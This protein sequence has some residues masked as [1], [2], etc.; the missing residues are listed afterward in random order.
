MHATLKRLFRIAYLLLSFSAFM[1]S[2]SESEPINEP[3]LPEIQVDDMDEEEDIEDETEDQEQANNGD[4]DN[5]TETEEV[6]ETSDE[7]ESEE[8]GN[9]TEDETSTNSNF[10]VIQLSGDETSAV[11]DSLV[12]A[13][14]AVGRADLTGTVKSVILTDENTEITEEG[15]SPKKLD[16]GFVLIGGDDLNSEGNTD[17]EKDISM[18][19]FI[20]GIEYRFG[21]SVPSGGKFMDC[22][23]D[24][25][26]DFEKKEMIFDNTTVS[27]T[28]TQVTL[29]LDG[30]IKWD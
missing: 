26:I 22:G 4:A 11:G 10:G 16:K 3:K 5:E 7:V 1:I 18:V 19:I 15:P 14:I 6:E 30:I 20:D 23:A 28:E 29:T 21:C 24:Y 9:D 27:N 25:K 8:E 13:H 2:C 12:V 17:A